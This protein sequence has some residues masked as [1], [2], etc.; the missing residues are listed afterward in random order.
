MSWLMG[1]SDMK[2]KIRF[3]RISELV[4]K[5]YLHTTTKIV[6]TEFLIKFCNLKKQ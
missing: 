5:H 2:T 4:I 1:K 6:E 3:Q